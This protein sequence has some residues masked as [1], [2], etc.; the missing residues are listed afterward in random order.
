M[1]QKELFS[2]F[3]EEKQKQYE[4]EIRQRYGEKAFEG[5]K[6]WNSYNADQKAVIQA[7]ARPF[8][9]ISKTT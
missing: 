7:K 1:K 3:S 8:I 4:A 9:R 6:D 5:V 2:G